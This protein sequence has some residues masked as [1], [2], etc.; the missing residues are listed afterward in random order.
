MLCYTAKKRFS[1]HPLRLF[2]LLFLMALAS[3]SFFTKKEQQEQAAIAQEAI[4]YTTHFEGDFPND[5]KPIIEK[6]SILRR[7]EKRPPLTVFALEKRAEKDMKEI[8]EE[9]N[10]YGYFDAKASFTMVENDKA[11]EITVKVTAGDFYTLSHLGIQYEG[12]DP[13]ITLDPASMNSAL[14]MGSQVNLK[15]A[16]DAARKV[17]KYFRNHGYPFARAL[18]LKGDLD[19]KEKTAKIFFVIK[20][21]PK[22]VFG[23][24]TVEGLTGLSETFVR[25]RFDYAE[26]DPFNEGKMDDTRKALTETGLFNDINIQAVEEDPSSKTAKIHVRLKEGPPRSFGF[27]GKY[28]SFD[29]FSGRTF[30]RHDNAF[31]GGESF[32]SSA[33]LGKKK[34]EAKL[35]LSIPDFL[36]PKQT[37]YNALTV[38]NEKTRAYKVQSG[39]I[40]AGL[41]RDIS[42][43]WAL[44][45]GVEFELARIK[46]N[47]VISHS[48]LFSVPVIL[49]LDTTKDILNP[50]EGMKLR[51]KSTPYFGKY[52]GKNGFWTNEAF[53]S[54][55]MGPK[56]QEGSDNDNATLLATWAKGGHITASSV[57][58]VPPTKRFYSGGGNSVRG[59]G[60]QLL[61]PLDDKRTPIGGISLVEF[62]VEPRIKITEQFGMI[63]FAEAGTVGLKNTPRF[64]SQNLLWGVGIGARYYTGIG[65]VRFDLGF[66]LKRRQTPGSRKKVDAPFQFYISVGQAF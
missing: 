40:A 51:L 58:F 6:A 48:R 57:N 3:C 14:A 12:E 1:F 44:S 4:P 61:G 32:E 10:I 33:I 49:E 25:N 46:K 37:L 39:K 59:Y 35:A 27:G 19:K 26:G 13:E 29:G 30:W 43:I 22:A 65:P 50:R 16:E 56:S 60:Y 15:K 8:T 31:G 64:D 2:A 7:L 9:L 28:S 11:Q 55:Y 63:A 47:S 5:L 53:T 34:S 36:A 62:G 24:T 18:D 41:S 23:K 45:Y 17:A 54:L 66:P 21:G 20:L 42:D 52:E 38:I